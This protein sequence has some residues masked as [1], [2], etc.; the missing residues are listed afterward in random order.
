MKSYITLSTIAQAQKQ[1]LA[2]AL[3]DTEHSFE[4]DWAREIGIN[5]DELI[6]QEPETG[7]EAVDT[8]ES[9]IRMGAG[10]VVWDSIAA[11]LPQAE[12]NKRMSKESVQPARLAALMSAGM[13]K[14]TAANRDTALLFVNQTRMNVGVMFGDPEV[15]AGGKALPYYASYRVALRKAGKVKDTSDGY[16]NEGKKVKINS[17][18]GINIRATLEKSKLSSPMQEVVFQ[19][20]TTEGAVDEIGYL[21]SAGLLNGII[22]HEGKSWWINE[23][24][25][26]IGIEKFRG[27]LAENPQA[28][29]AIRKVILPTAGNEGQGKK[30]AGKLKKK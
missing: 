11:S 14:I 21:I 18:I 10:L 9:L 29:E 27:W 16:D 23:D 24:E 12:G 17:I 25:K 8:I 6:Y 4:P 30:R 7:E 20:K 15:V 2:C 1:G 19:W 26:T 13:R 5:C 3:V 28:Q 22:K